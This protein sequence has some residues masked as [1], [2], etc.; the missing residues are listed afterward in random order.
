M[1]DPRR[2]RK[3]YDVPKILWEKERIAEERALVGEYGLKRVREI[4]KAKA[5]LRKL[6]RAVRSLLG[7]GKEKEISA[8]L[9]RAIKMGY[10]TERSTDSI[11]S[12]DN[13][14]ILNRRLQTIVYKA[15]LATSMAHARELI[16]HGKIAI[17][18]KKIS[19]PGYLVPVEL[20]SSI[21]FYKGEGS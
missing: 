2:L 15:G 13:R 7:G 6:R 16:T 3:K 18:G 8:V 1:G 4:W 12:L 11:F 14:S 5:E 20:E 10:C 9:D 21:G 17:A 19:V